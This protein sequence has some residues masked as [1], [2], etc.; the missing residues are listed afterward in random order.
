MN[1]YDLIDY[2]TDAGM[3]VVVLDE[4]TAFPAYPASEAGEEQHSA[5]GACKHE[6]PRSHQQLSDDRPRVL[7]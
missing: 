7:Q 4:D 3:F 2:F 6:R 5:P 1:L